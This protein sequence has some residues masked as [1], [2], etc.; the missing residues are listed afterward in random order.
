MLDQPG[1]PVGNDPFEDFAATGCEAVGVGI[2]RRFTA[3]GEGD[4]YGF[5]PRVRDE[6]VA[7]QGVEKQKDVIL[8]VGGEICYHSLWIKS[9][10]IDLLLFFCVACFSSLRVEV[11]C[12]QSYQRCESGG[13]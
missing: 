9:G 11:I 6:S 12:Y 3:L 7:I 1:Q 8:V 4:N 5:F 2:M 13:D 10:P